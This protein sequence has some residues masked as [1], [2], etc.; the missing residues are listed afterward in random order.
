[1]QH[2]HESC[3]KHG[4]NSESVSQG[5]LATSMP[6]KDPKTETN[7]VTGVQPCWQRGKSRQG[8]REVQGSR[9]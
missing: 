8:G 6:P 3:L 2:G 4:I 9:V 5:T 7:Q 1:M